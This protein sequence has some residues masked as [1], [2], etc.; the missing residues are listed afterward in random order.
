[1]KTPGSIPELRNLIG[2]LPRADAAAEATARDRD[3]QLTKPAGSL[4]RLEVAL[5]T[6]RELE[7]ELSASGV[8]SDGFV[9][10]EIAECLLALGRSAEAR[11]YFR[12]AHA[13]L[14]VDAWLVESEPERVER[15]RE[16]GAE[17]G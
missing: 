15:L 12:K 5:Q 7:V 14:A 17:G 11:P 8:E 3:A 6:Q 16:L 10:E 4:G 9:Y 1:M 13:L 2:D